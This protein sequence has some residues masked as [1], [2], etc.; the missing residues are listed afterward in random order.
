MP[1]NKT[2]KCAAKRL[3]LTANGKIK[4][5]KAG[6]KHLLGG[7]SRKRKRHLRKAGMISPADIRRV[8]EL[9]LPK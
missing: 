3:W 5:F 2:K 7:K 9:L 1:K 4:Y 8:R 6:R